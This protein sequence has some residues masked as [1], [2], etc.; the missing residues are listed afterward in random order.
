[1]DFPDFTDGRTKTHSALKLFIGLAN[2][3]FMD[4]KLIVINEISKALA[5][6]SANIH[7]LMGARYAK[8][9]NHLFI[10]HPETGKAKMIAITTSLRKSLDNNAAMP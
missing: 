6:A 1:M 4:W 2:A 5:P 7:Q 10:S 3:A 8:S 9:I